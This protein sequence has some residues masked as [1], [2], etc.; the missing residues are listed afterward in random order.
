MASRW[1]LIQTPRGWYGSGVRAPYYRNSLP[2]FVEP[3]PN[4]FSPSDISGLQIWFDA[5]NGGSIGIDESNNISAWS[6]L[7]SAGGVA[8]QN[9]GFARV[10]SD[11]GGLNNVQF[12]GSDLLMSNV[13]LPYYSRTQFVVFK[14]ITDMQYA[15]YPYLTFLNGN[16]TGA[17]Q[18][19]VSWDS[20]SGLFQYTICQNGIS[21]PLIGTDSVNPLSNAFL[22]MYC[23]DSTDSINSILSLNNGSNINTGSGGD[24]FFQG[25]TSFLLNN[26]AGGS[27]QGQNLCEILEYD[28]VLSTSNIS[29]VTSYLSTK[30]G[31]TFSPAPAPG[32]N[33]SII[34][35]AYIEGEAPN[36]YWCDN[37]ANVEIPYVL[38]EGYDGT[39]A[40]RNGTPVVVTNVFYS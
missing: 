9:N 8:V 7:G 13:A 24:E 20:N 28:S 15:Y 32:E 38:A 27:G 17:M 33:T 31:L 23:L 26:A 36:F 1:G 34:Y 25:T 39:T 35:G 4:P 14:S 10:V 5:N 30:W 40:Y 18:S 12:L 19:G 11:V 37:L 2:P 3:L 6:N 29:T 21:C 22:V 16:D